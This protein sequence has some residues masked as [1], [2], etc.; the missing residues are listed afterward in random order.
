MTANTDAMDTPVQKAPE[1]PMSICLGFGVGTVGVSILLNSVTIYFPALMAT[2][3][4]QS[5][6]IAGALLTISKLYDIIADLIIGARSDATRSRWGRRRPFLL[7]GAIFSGLTFPAIFAPPALEGT[8]LMIY[9]GAVLI[10]YS[11]GYSLFNVP[12]LAMPSEMTDDY[13]QR[14]RLLSFRTLFVSVGQLA[15][16]AG[17]AALLLHFGRDRAGFATTGFILTAVIVVAMLTCFLATAKARMIERHEGPKPPMRDQIR[18]VLENKPILILLSVK[19]LHL[20][21]LASVST[22]GLLFLINVTKD[23]YAGQEVLSISSNVAIAL[24]MPMWS[25]VAHRIGKHRAFMIA[26]S[27][28]IVMALSWL[29]A[30]EGVPLWIMGVRGVGLGLSSGGMLLMGAAML[31]DTMDYD[32]RRT[33]LRREG[34]FS[35]FYAIVEKS[36]FAIGPAIMGAYLAGAGY[37][38]TKGGQ[39][40]TQPDSVITALY[41]GVAIVPTIMLGASIFVLMFYDLDEKRLGDTGKAH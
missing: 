13:H 37:I 34:L 23:G 27:M 30:A 39:V 7:A 35:S 25:A 8:D 4:G 29:L 41:V 33:G 26:T 17:T 6:A 21:S 3:L 10:L 16:G 5:T 24:S 12:Y 22:T 32:R 1:L 38:P 11:T 40:I 36:A 19:F 18:M 28:Y 20:L 2:V 15:A 14:T 31:P 9:F